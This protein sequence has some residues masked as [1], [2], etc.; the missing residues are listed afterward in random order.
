MMNI[1][2]AT[3]YLDPAG[4]D[5]TGDWSSGAPW[6]N[7]V[8]AVNN[9]GNTD[10]I[11][12]NEGTLVQTVGADNRDMG[13]RVVYSAS[14]NAKL[15]ILDYSA[16]PIVRTA[17]SSQGSLANIQFANNFVAS[18]NRSM[19]STFNVASI[20][21]C[22]FRDC[23]GWGDSSSTS[24]RGGIF[25]N[26]TTT[27]NRCIFRN[28]RYQSWAIG[29]AIIWHRANSEHTT[30]V[31]SCLF[32]ND[33]TEI[34]GTLIPTYIF[35]VRTEW[36]SSNLTITIKNSIVMLASGTLVYGYS[37]EVN[38]SGWS[39]DITTTY[40]CLNNVSYTDGE[41]GTTTV[42]PLFV[43]PNNWDFHLKPT[44]PLIWVASVS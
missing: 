38:S 1:L 28:C 33:G 6:L 34:A 7:L 23:T 10:T 32:Y 31:N 42:D 36:S 5:S 4:N 22:I 21:G 30:T 40:S 37:N 12:V 26:S 39:V 27:L 35:S 29:W 17:G 8:Y 11:I 2:M 18:T 20:N 14:G 16:T 3:F 13:D 9:T 24:S 44:S 41:I 19:F 25:L 43:D 15:T